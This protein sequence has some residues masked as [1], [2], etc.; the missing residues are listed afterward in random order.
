MSAAGL[1]TTPSD[2]CRVILEIQHAQSE[3]GGAKILSPG[4]VNAERRAEDWD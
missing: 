2:Y 1:W 3:R 4:A